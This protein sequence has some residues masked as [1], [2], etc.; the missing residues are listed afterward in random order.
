MTSQFFM[1]SE[2]YF[3]GKLMKHDQVFFFLA[4]W[5][6]LLIITTI[7]IETKILVFLQNTR[8]A[9]HSHGKNYKDT[10]KNEYMC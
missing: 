7:K 9:L 3:L 6:V 1:F 2:F 4:Y 5:K 10:L 8:F